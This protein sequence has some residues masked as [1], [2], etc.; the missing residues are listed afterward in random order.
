MCK[1]RLLC[2]ADEAEELETGPS[3]DYVEESARADSVHINSMQG[4]RRSRPLRIVG[5]IQNRE[6]SI[7]IDTGSDRDF[8]HPA[9]AEQLHI[10]LSPIRPFK[11]F[12][13]NGAALLCTHM[14]KQT[15]LDVQ[16]TVFLVDLHILPVHGPD[17][18]LGMDWLESLGKVTT[19]FVGKTLEFT[20]GERPV[21]LR[22]ILRPPS[23]VSFHSLASWLPSRENIECVEILLLGPDELAQATATQPDIPTDLPP[24]VAAVLSQFWDVFTLPEGMPPQRPF[25]HHIHLLPGSRPVNVRPYRYP[26][27]QKNEIERQVQD[28]LDQG[29]IQRSSSPFLSPVLLIRKKDGTFRFCID[30]RALNTATVPDHFPI[31]TADELFD[32][33]GKARVFTKLDLRSGY[34]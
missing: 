3:E 10:H 25:D 18:I 13:G 12:V 9:V 33:L 32:E 27:F 19:D 16:G 1:Q 8:M 14:A 4:D 34:H 2:Y 5:L 21:T 26:Y 30:Y 15:K 11:V 23:R 22:G 24:E 7:L 17:I 31:P 20:Q 6:V 29:I 28:M